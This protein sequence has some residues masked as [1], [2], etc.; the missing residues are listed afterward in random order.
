MKLQ[1]AAGFAVVAWYL[2]LPPP[3]P[4]GTRL[5]FEPQSEWKILDQFVSE[6]ECRQMLAKLIERMPD[7]AIDTAQCVPSN[8][9]YLTPEPEPK[10]VGDRSGG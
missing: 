8:D 5:T 10:V 9:P 7:T 2:M 6:S 3:A 1:H 4:F